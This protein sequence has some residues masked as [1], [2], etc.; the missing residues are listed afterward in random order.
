M[1]VEHTGWWNSFWI[2]EQRNAVACG[3]WPYVSVFLPCLA[4]DSW[5]GCSCSSEL[6]TNQ[7]KLGSLLTCLSTGKYRELKFIVVLSL[8]FHGI[9]GV[10]WTASDFISAD[11]SCHHQSLERWTCECS[12]GRDWE[13][14]VI[15]RLR[16]CKLVQI[17]TSHFMLLFFSLF[18]LFY[19]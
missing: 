19:Y 8:Y 6:K 3:V 12:T 17:K 15:G 1:V 10:Y 16:W 14:G 11:N 13:E 2:M 4:G 18:I 7:S 5:S 9:V